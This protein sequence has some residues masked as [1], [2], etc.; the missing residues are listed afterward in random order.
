RGKR[1]E[2]GAIASQWADHLIVT[3]DNPRDEN[4]QDIVDDILNG[5]RKERVRVIRDRKQAIEAAIL[6]SGADDWIVI[7]GKGHEDYQEIAGVRY[8]FSDAETVQRAIEL[9]TNGENAVE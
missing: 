1:A 6:E 4:G 8:P 5:C 2:M 7:A 3:D 9:R